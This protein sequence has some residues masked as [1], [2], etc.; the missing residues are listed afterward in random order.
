MD[1]LDRIPGDE[2]GRMICG[3]FKTQ[4]RELKHLTNV[5]AVAQGGNESSFKKL[6]AALDQFGEQLSEREKA[7]AAQQAEQEFVDSLLQ[8]I[9]VKA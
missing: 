2:A 4:G 9:P 6:F 8:I 1:A 7:A 3:V 5:M